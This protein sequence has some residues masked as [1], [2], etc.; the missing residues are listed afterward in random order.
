MTKFLPSIKTGEFAGQYN[1]ADIRGSYT[2]DDISN[3][4]EIPIEDL[5]KA[6]WRRGPLNMLLFNAKNLKAC[7][8]CLLQ[9]EK[10]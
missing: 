9:K 3:A 8:R 5:G 6:F 7:M 10:K 4:F 1:P 2:F